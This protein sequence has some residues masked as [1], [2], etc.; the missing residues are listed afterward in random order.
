MMAQILHNSV[1]PVMELGFHS[2]AMENV[3]FE[4]LWLH[5]EKMKNHATFPNSD[6]MEFDGAVVEKT[7]YAIV[8]SR[9]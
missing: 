6:K 3:D 7:P 4:A 1:H 2:S 9:W 5:M 8:T